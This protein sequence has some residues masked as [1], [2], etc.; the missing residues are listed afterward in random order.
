MGVAYS[1]VARKGWRWQYVTTSTLFS[2]YVGYRLG[3]RFIV[4]L[5]LVGPLE[6]KGVVVSEYLG[7]FYLLAL[8]SAVSYVIMILVLRRAYGKLASA[9]VSER[10]VEAP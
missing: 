1:G 5:E 3:T 4:A 8:G 10:I 7:F 2:G 6:T 9:R